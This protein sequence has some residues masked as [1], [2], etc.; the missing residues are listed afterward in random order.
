MEGMGASP[1]PRPP[2]SRRAQRVALP[3]PPLA[4]IA[5][6]LTYQIQ[7]AHCPR[8]LPPGAA[9][10][11]ERTGPGRRPGP[12]SS[13]TPRPSPLS[14]ARGSELPTPA[15]GGPQRECGRTARAEVQARGRGGR[16]H[17]G[18][19]GGGAGPGSEGAERGGAGDAG[20]GGALARGGV[21]GGAGPQGWKAGDVGAGV[22]GGGGT[23]RRGLSEVL[24]LGLWRGWG[25]ALP[26][27]CVFDLGALPR[28]C[29]AGSGPF[30]LFILR[31]RKW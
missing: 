25:L 28:T 31:K 23:G 4:V 8:G 29:T 13:R 9:R 7:G 6:L 11:C 10:R 24:T 14:P 3:V 17:G 26:A 27:L 18:E 21:G 22:A 16:G 2:H 12:S 1:H 30:M 15:A 19:G 5:S 20:G